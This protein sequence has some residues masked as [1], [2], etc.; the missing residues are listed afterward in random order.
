[1]SSALSFGFWVF[2]SL[3]REVGTPFKCL[4]VTAAFLFAEGFMQEKGRKSMPL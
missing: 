3:T 2:G 4:A 1:M